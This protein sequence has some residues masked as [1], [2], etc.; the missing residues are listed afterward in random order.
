M[1][2]ERF[3]RRSG[4][5]AGVRVGMADEHDGYEMVC[6]IFPCQSAS[7]SG[8]LRDCAYPY[9][10][11]FVGVEEMGLLDCMAFC[12]C[13]QSDPLPEGR[14]GIHADSKLPVSGQRNMVVVHMVPA[15]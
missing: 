5:G 2:A 13:G 4:A 6:G 15:I 9:G 1:A 3:C 7:V 12:E 14:S 11:D 8:L 10:S